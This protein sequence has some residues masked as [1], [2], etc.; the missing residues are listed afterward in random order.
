MF[1]VLVKRTK[2][3]LR[4]LPR[5]VY[6]G[7]L[8][9]VLIYLG[10]AG[11]MSLATPATANGDTPQHLDYIWRLSK[12]EFPTR[13]EGVTYPP[14][15]EIRGYREQQ[16]AAHPPLFYLLQV[17][18]IAPLLNSGDWQTAIVVGRIYNLLIG[19]VALLVIAWAGWVF[20]GDKKH[21]MTVAVPAVAAIFYRFVRLN[22]DY[23]FDALLVIFTTL[24]L[25]LSYKILTKGLSRNNGIALFV[26][27]VLGMYT[28]AS[29]IV[30]LLINL[31]AIVVSSYLHAHKASK[32]QDILKGIALAA[33]ILGF[34]MLS[35]GWYYYNRNYKASGHWFTPR[36]DSYTGGRIPKTL[37]EVITSND[38]WSL[39]YGDY[40]RYLHI[41]VAFLSFGLAGYLTFTKQQLKRAINKNTIIIAALFLLAILGT[42]ATQLRHAVGVGSINF[43]Y[44]LPAMAAFGVVLGY[45]L[46]KFELVKGQLV[47]FFVVLI[48]L[49]SVYASFAANP[50]SPLRNLVR[51]HWSPS[52]YIGVMLMI[53][54]VVGGGLLARALYAL[55]A[56]PPKPSRKKRLAQKAA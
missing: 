35:I 16:Q 13:S 46:L 32:R 34:V 23:S 11:S 38:L 15:V 17:P 51:F 44:M 22:L 52:V 5:P 4:A 12:G 37:R 43:R 30:F 25:I 20:G 18:V 48:G 39:F 54:F 24:S 33:A 47:T 49:S 42:F 50:D 3:Q 45:G 7:L 19:V 21:L 36:L 9:V 8:G 26:V 53:L 55:H 27:S 10:I 14:F 29:F 6:W 28:K 56:N 1:E 31:A 41:S 40:S 2:K